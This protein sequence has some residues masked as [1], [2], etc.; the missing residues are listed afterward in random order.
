M[1]FTP[2]NRPGS[3]IST[4]LPLARTASLAVFH[5]TRDPPRPGQQSGAGP[6]GLPAPT[7]TRAATASPAARPRGWC[8]GAT[9]AHNHC[10]G[11]G[12]PSGAGSWDASPAARAPTAG[13]RSRE[14]SLRSH[15]ADTTIGVVGTDDPARQHRTVGLKP[16]PDDFEAEL[17]RAGESGQ[18]RAGQAK[19]TSDTSRSFGWAV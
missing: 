7:A 4:R 10:T 14:R 9:R 12:A 5:A 8:L 15:T 13:P 1:T 11:S 16:L 19:V 17:V 6:P 3:S 2:S 18:V